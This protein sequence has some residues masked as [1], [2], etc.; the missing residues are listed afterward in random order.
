[1]SSPDS[2]RDRIVRAAFAL[3]DERGFEATSVDEIA[4]RAHVGR[5]TLFRQ[6]RSKEALVFPDHDALLRQAQERL[7][8]AGPKAMPGAVMDVATTVF[9]HYL[10][11]GE[12]ARSRYQLTSAVPALRDYEIATVSRYARLCAQNMRGISTDNWKAQ[13]RAELYAN[14]V[15]AAHNYVLRR[16]LRHETTRAREELADALAATHV[17]LHDHGSAHTAVVVLSTTES[18]DSLVPRLRDAIDGPHPP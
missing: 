8:V 1:V 18:V 17:I 9:D 11:E 3:F 16:W 13:L 6:F 5:T 10:A 2:P 4:A 15:V 7:S 14:A 12:I